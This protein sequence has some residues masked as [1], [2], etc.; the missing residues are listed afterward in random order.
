MVLYVAATTATF[1][2]MGS[3]QLVALQLGALQLVALQLAALQLG[4]LAAEGLT[5]EEGL[6]LRGH[7]YPK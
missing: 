2:N 6:V 4:G 1:P 5:A 7:S 3:L